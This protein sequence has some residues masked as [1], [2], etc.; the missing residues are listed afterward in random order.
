MQRQSGKRPRRRYARSACRRREIGSPSK[1]PTC[2]SEIVAQQTPGAMQSCLHRFR[3]QPEQPAVSSTLISSTNRATKTT[4]NGLPAAHRSRVPEGDGFRG[5][6]RCVGIE[7][8]GRERDDLRV[9]KL[10]VRDAVPVDRDAS[11]AEPPI[12][13]VD[14]DPGQPGAELRSCR[15][16]R[17]AAAS[18]HI[19][20]LHD[21]PWP[22]GRL[23][24][25]SG[26]VTKKP[27]IVVADDG[28]SHRRLVARTTRAVR[29]SSAAN[30]ARDCS[31]GMA[32]PRFHCPALD[33][34]LHPRSHGTGRAPRQPYR[35]KAPTAK[36]DI[37]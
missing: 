37:G 12:G 22:R 2:R 24:R 5:R 11:P 26:P 10:R 14:R 35:F 34:G 32:V 15:G 4:R 29:V 23:S 33:A 20:F 16:N 31:L 17:R 28:R 6:T 18:L 9:R 27:A 8:R 30:A 25:S 3:P 36:R 19:R 13:F 1:G 7:L 21:R